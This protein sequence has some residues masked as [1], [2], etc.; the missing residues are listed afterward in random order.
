LDINV[1]SHKIQ[2]MFRKVSKTNVSAMKNWLSWVA[3]TTFALHS[4]EKTTAVM[5]SQCR[6]FLVIANKNRTV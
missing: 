3:R 6:L 5:K 2:N 1:A 4:I